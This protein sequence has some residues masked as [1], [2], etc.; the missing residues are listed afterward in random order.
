VVGGDGRGCGCGCGCGCG[1]RRWRYLVATIVV[2]RR[3]QVAPVNRE[4]LS[5]AGVEPKARDARPRIP[6]VRAVPSEVNDAVPVCGRC[7][8][9][10]GESDFVVEVE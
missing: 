4:E 2:R 1:W 9:S 7:R 8:G 5:C 3:V 6:T 10:D